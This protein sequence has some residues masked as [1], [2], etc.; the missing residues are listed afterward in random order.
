MSR[1]RNCGFVSFYGLPYSGDMGCLDSTP[2][3][4]H[5]ETNRSVGQPA[6]PALCPSDEGKGGCADGS[7]EG[8]CVETPNY[9][10]PY[11]NDQHCVISTRRAG[12]T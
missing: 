12:W 8:A 6:C 7:A 9:P 4:C 2:Q 3:S 5:A 11:G 10:G 1:P